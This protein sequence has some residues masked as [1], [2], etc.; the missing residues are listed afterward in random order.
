MLWERLWCLHLL[1]VT[2]AFIALHALSSLKTSPALLEK[3]IQGEEPL[4]HHA[5]MALLVNSSGKVP[6]PAMPLFAD[7]WGTTVLPEQ[8][9]GGSRAQPENT[10]QTD[11]L[12]LPALRVKCVFQERQRLIA[13]LVTSRRQQALFVHPLTQV[14]VL[15]Q[16]VLILCLALQSLLDS[17]RLQETHQLPQH[18]QLG[19]NVRLASKRL[20]HPA[21]SVPKEVL[22]LHLLVLD[23]SKMSPV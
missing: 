7:L 11:Q 8:L 15:L 23:P 9:P 19:L 12:A 3:Q 20:A 13:R 21:I 1:I 6:L 16:L 22:L 17:G 5:S 18:A 4:Q 10:L 2:L 14:K